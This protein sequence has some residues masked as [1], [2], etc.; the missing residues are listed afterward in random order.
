MPHGMSSTLVLEVMRAGKIGVVASLESENF[1]GG[2]KAGFGTA[3]NLVS[4]V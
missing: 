2:G 4:R 3:V 1:G